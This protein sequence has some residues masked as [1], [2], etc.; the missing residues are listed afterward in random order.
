MPVPTPYS[1]SHQL[2]NMANG[3]VLLRSPSN[4]NVELSPGDGNATIGE[5]SPGGRA[6]NQVRN[7]GL[8]IGMTQGD[9]QEVAFSITLKHVGAFTDPVQA[10]LM[11]AILRTGSFGTEASYD[12]AGVV[13]THNIELTCAR[14][15]LSTTI[16]L[17]NVFCAVAYAEDPAANTLTI[18]GTAYGFASGGV[19][20]L[21]V[22]YS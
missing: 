20:T 4:R 5:I 19:V 8:V 7:R 1:G 17:N 10:T 3:I 11:D 14:N 13:P 21:P 22:V 12:P 2:F 6:A 15:G 9:S 16:T 18:S